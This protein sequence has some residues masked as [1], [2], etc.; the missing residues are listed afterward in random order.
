[1][2]LHLSQVLEQQHYAVAAH[3]AQKKYSSR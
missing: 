3:M 1:M 2:V